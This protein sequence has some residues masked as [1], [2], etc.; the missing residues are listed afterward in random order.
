MVAIFQ[1]D[2]AKYE[3]IT[4][5]LKVLSHSVR[6]RIIQNLIVKGPLN[7]TE[8]YTLLGM[9]QSTISQ[10]LSRLKM[11]KVVSCERKG[12]EVYYRVDDEMIIRLLDVLGLVS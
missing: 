10:H 1:V 4:K 12:L 9:P 11:I 5:M 7:V 3:R 8:I 2:T 6:L